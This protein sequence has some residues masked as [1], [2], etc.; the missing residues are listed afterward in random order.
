MAAE[1]FA[2]GYVQIDETPI[3][4]LAPGKGKDSQ[5]YLWTSHRPGGDTVYHWPNREIAEITPAAWAEAKKATVRA[6][7]RQP[8]ACAA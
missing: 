3:K 4:Y 1:Q 6:E 7:A 5:G 2:H 8:I